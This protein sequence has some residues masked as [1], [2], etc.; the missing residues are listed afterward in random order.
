MG[1]VPRDWWDELRA[2]E[3]PFTPKEKLLIGVMFAVC[4]GLGA[5]A[6]RVL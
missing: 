5:G 2:K 3:P 1:A 6:F 4:V